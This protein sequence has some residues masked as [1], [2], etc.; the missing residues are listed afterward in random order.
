[1]SVLGYEMKPFMYR[2][3]AILMALDAVKPILLAALINSVVLK[4][5]GGWSILSFA[6]RSVTPAVSPSLLNIPLASFSSHIRPALCLTSNSMPSDSVAIISQYGRDTCA[7]RSRSLSTSS[8]SVGVWTRPTLRNR[9]PSL[10]AVVEMYLVSAAP[11]IR[12]M[13]CLLSPAA[14]RLKSTG[15]RFSNAFSISVLVM[16][17]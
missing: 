11:H 3:S 7:S 12:S 4:G 9:L 10:P 1:M 17:L 2:L 16:V 13:T 5:I 8:A 15:L 6:L 14:A